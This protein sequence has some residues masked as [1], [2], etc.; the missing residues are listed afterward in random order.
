VLYGPFWNKAIHDA[1]TVER[2]VAATPEEGSERM[3]GILKLMQQ[4]TPDMF[5]HEVPALSSKLR[6]SC[7][8]IRDVLNAL[9]NAGYRVSLT[10]CDNN[11]FKTNAPLAVIQE[12]MMQCNSRA[13]GKFSFEPNELVSGIL[14]RQYHRGKI[15]SGLKPL[16]LPKK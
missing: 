5:Y 16:S 11:A 10:H 6:I 14:D 8:K 2:M 15:R 12:I 3:L 9:A 13:G 4:E 1:A 7:C